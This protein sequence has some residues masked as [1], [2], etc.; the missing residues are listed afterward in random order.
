MA[1]F[2]FLS[3][4]ER[5]SG[6]PDWSFQD[7]AVSKLVKD[8]SGNPLL[9]TLLIIPTGGGKT[10]AAIRAISKLIDKGTL[11]ANHR[12]LWIVHTEALQDQAIDERD[13]TDNA[14][15]FRFN[16]S[17]SPILEVHMKTRAANIINSPERQNYK[18]LIID[19]AHHSR[20]ATYASFFGIRIGILGLTATPTRS[21]SAVLEFDNVAYSISFKELM[22]RGVVLLPT[23]ESVYTNIV[24]RAR[25]LGVFDNDR[26][27]DLFNIEARNEIIANEIFRRSKQCKKVLVFVGTNKHALNLYKTLNSYNQRFEKPYGHVGYIYGGDH[28]EKNI[29]NKDYLDEHRT[30]GSSILVNCKL[31]NEGYNDPSL[32]TIVMATPTSSILYYLQC[33]GRVVRRNHGAAASHDVYVIE[34]ADKLPNVKYHIDN[35]WLFADISDYLEPDVSEKLF[36][37]YE[38]FLIST[39]VLFRENRIDTSFARAIPQEEDLTEA[40]LLLFNEAPDSSDSLWKPIFITRDNRGRYVDLFNKI[41]NNIE[42]FYSQ[43]FDYLL[44]KFNVPADDFYFNSRPFRASFFMALK[45]AYD[46]KTSRQKVD[47]LKYIT[48]TRMRLGWWQ[49]LLRRIVRL[50]GLA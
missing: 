31:L 7:D 49:R 13:N 40:S 44:K 36:V 28:N 37:D 6:Q 26:D 1:I 32:D 21:D 17:L 30:L 14:I 2:S 15:R 24:I 33:V 43:N 50:F 45:R 39:K 18:L 48:F 11:D 16:K 41:G 35:R 46:R 20:A 42:I 47:C 22:D 19:E 9:K 5:V 8:F 25:S 10:V 29:S 34:I 4:Q 38:D 27:L 23:F 3:R 12:A